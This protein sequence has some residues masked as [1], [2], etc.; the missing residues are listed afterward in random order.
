[1]VQ[2][3]ILVRLVVMHHCVYFEKVF[4]INCS[5]V[6]RCTSMDITLVLKKLR[7]FSLNLLRL[8]LMFSLQF[9]GSL[10]QCTG[11]RSSGYA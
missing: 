7:F 8:S 4:F 3:G 10:D 5:S 1:M 2:A 11:T 6:A 9:L